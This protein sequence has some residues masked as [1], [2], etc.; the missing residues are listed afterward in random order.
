MLDTNVLLRFRF[1]QRR[2]G[3]Q[4]LR[5]VEQAWEAQDVAVSAI[6]FWE[7]AMLYD[8]GRVSLTEDVALWRQELLAAGL[9]EIRVDGAIG[10]LAGSL[11]YPRGDPADRLIIATAL[12][13][14]H[15]LVTLD[16]TILA[17]PGPLNRLRADD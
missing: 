16:R 17:W 8:K 14:D 11:D 4:T 3:R 9:T 2:L 13:G 7:T 6:T 5:V 12:A 15:Q 10:V 1:Q